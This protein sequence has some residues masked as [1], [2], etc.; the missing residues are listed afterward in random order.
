MADLKLDDLINDMASSMSDILNKDVS[1]LRGYSKAKATSIA[2]FTRLI[3]EGYANGEIGEQELESELD[4]LD[5]MVAR[6]VR[7]IKG[8]KN[9]TIERLINAATTSLYGAIKTVAA[10]AGV[11]LPALD[12]PDN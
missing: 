9:T 3:A 7:N 6:F 2:R 5:G 12:L 8:L 11:T 10:G 1:I 4:E